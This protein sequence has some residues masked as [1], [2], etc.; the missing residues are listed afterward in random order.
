MTRNGLCRT[1]SIVI[2]IMTALALTVASAGQDE[3]PSGR[4]VSPRLIVKV[5]RGHMDG[6][7]S[8]TYG[9]YR[10]VSSS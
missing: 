8:V 9:V 1:M 3:A 6:L 4:S 5:P 2:A 7:D 10:T